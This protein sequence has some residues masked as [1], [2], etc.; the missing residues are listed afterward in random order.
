[1]LEL[2]RVNPTV[3]MLTSHSCKLLKE[4]NYRSYLVKLRMQQENHIGSGGAY[5]GEREINPREKRL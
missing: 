5:K 4:V 2:L 3:S 1:M